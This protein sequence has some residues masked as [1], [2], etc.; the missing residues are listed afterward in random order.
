MLQFIVRQKDNISK[1][2]AADNNDAQ[3]YIFPEHFIKCLDA[4]VLTLT[5]EGKG[6][7]DPGTTE[8]LKPMTQGTN[9]VHQHLK[10]NTDNVCLQNRYKTLKRQ[11]V[12][13]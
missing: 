7:F 10:H 6:S 8:D 2:L 1:K 13:P 11:E 9:N 3:V 5:K 4:W 12:T